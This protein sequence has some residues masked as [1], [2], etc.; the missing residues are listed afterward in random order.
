[1]YGSEAYP[2]LT[3]PPT[4][5]GPIIDGDTFYFSCDIT[6][7]GNDLD[8]AFEFVWLF[9]GVENDTT[10]P[11][12]I[13]SYST[14]SARLDGSKLKGLLNKNIGC[15]V[16]AFYK[17]F[18]QNSNKV[19]PWMESPRTYWA[20]IKTE[21]T[22]IYLPTDE[23]R[24]EVVIKPP[25]SIKRLQAHAMQVRL[26]QQTSGNVNILYDRGQIPPD[27]GR[28]QGLAGLLQPSDYSGPFTIYESI[29]RSSDTFGTGEGQKQKVYLE[30]RD[31]K[32]CQMVTDPHITGLEDKRQFHLLNV[33]DYTAYENIRRDFEVQIRT[34]PCNNDKATCICGVAVRE[35][36]DL[37]RVNGCNHGFYG[38]HVGSPE[39][40]VPRPLREGTTILQATDGSTITLYFPSGSEIRVT[41]SALY[42]GHLNLDLSVPGSDFPHGRGLCGTFDN[43]ANNELT[44]RNGFVDKMPANNVPVKFTESWKI[45]NRTSLFDIIPPSSGNSSV[46]LHCICGKNGD[47]VTC[48]YKTNIIK[49]QCRNCRVA[50]KCCFV[51]WQPTSGKRSANGG[52]YIDSD[53]VNSVYDP[54]RYADFQPATLSWPTPTGINESQAEN[55]CST[56]LRQSQ[57]WSHCQDKTQEIQ[58]LIE[59]CKIDIQMADK[60]TGLEPIV[61]AFMTIC[62]LELAK[63]PDNYVSTPN[64]ESIL[65]PAISDDVCNPVCFINGHCNKGNCVC[66]KGFIGDNCQI[67]DEPPTLS[68]IRGSSLCDFNEKPCRKI[69]IDATNIQNTETMAC[70]VQEIM[71]DGSV[72]ESFSKEEAVFLTLNKLGCSLPDAGIKTGSLIAGEKLSQYDV[73]GSLTTLSSNN[74]DKCIKGSKQDDATQATDD[75]CLSGNHKNLTD[76]RRSVSYQ[77]AYPESPLCDYDLIAA[78]TAL[79]STLTCGTTVPIWMRGTHPSTNDGIQTRQACANFQNGGASYIECCGQTMDIRVKNC[80]KFFVYYL[81]SV[82]A[83][84]MAYCA[85]KDAPCPAGTWSPTGF[86]PGCK[87]FYPQLTDPPRLRGP[88]IER[89]TFY[90]TCDLNFS[91]NDLDQAF[92][93][94]WLF[95]GL[96]D[97]KVTPEVVSE[98]GRSAR[99]DGAKLA[100]LLNKNTEPS[101]ITTMTNEDRKNVMVKSTVPVLCDSRFG[102]DEFCCLRISISEGG[103]DT[104]PYPIVWSC[105]YLICMSAWNTT[106]QEVSVTFP[107]IVPKTAMQ[108]GNKDLLVSFASLRVAEPS[109]YQ[110]IFQG[111]KIPSVHV[112]TETRNSKLC[113]ISEQHITGLEDKSVTDYEAEGITCVTYFA[114]DSVQIQT[115]PCYRERA[116]RA[117]TCVCGVAVREKDDL[118]RINGCNH[119][120]YGPSVGSPEITVPRRLREG[121]RITQARDGSQISLYFPSS[122]Q[123]TINTSSGHLSLNISVPGTDYMDGRG[124]CGTFDNNPTNEL[125]HRSGFVDK[126]PSDGVPESFTESWKND[127][128]SSLFQSLPQSLGDSYAPDYCWCSEDDF[129]VNCNYRRTDGD[130]IVVRTFHF[131]HDNCTDY[132]ILRGFSGTSWD[133]PLSGTDTYPQLT[134][135]PSLRGPVIERNTFYFTCDLTF[136]GNDTDQV[137]EF[138]WLFNGLEDPKVPPEIVPF[139]VR[140][141]RLEGAKLTGLLNK[142]VRIGCKVRGFFNRTAD[143]RGPWLQSTTTYWAGIRAEPSSITIRAEEDRKDLTIKSTLPILMGR[144]EM[145]VD[146]L[147]LSNTCKYKLCTS[148]WSSTRQE[149]TVTVSVV[150]R[151]TTIQDGTKTLLLSFPSLVVTEANPYL[152][153][154][155]GLKINSVQIRTWP[156]FRERTDRAVTCIC[157]VA[158]REKDDLIRINGCDHGFY[159]QSV[160]SPEITVPRPLREGTRILQATDGS[161][162]IIYFLS[163]S[164][165]K[166]TASSIFGGHLNLEIS[167]PGTDYLK[168]KGLCGTFDNNPNNELTH[169][170]GFVDIMPADSVPESFTESWKIESTVK[171]DT[172]DFVDTRKKHRVEM[173][174]RHLSIFFY[175]QSNKLSPCTV[176]EVGIPPPQT[177]ATEHS[178]GT[179]NRDFILL[180]GKQHGS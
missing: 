133:I 17:L 77:T 172:V 79:W 153:I 178:N 76:V 39:I 120:F 100:G 13:V 179:D 30:Q 171:T 177:K 7:N 138:V 27:S 110:Q 23:D 146:R 90:F 116:D 87:E 38:Q 19:G 22:H 92:E 121:T 170:D 102:A 25:S 131:P 104:A 157:G 1:M 60:Y 125:T 107:V 69:F 32:L 86:P 80:G 174:D 37:I 147:V 82:P 46:P 41:A 156:C 81:Y 135:P 134:D 98:P 84:P 114:L 117:V 148:S 52:L 159:G 73:S 44:H 106:L 62:Q 162:I 151:M 57:L 74:C 142:N 72:S 66:N 88:V 49:L 139:T 140:S 51:G 54:S 137:F 122:S 166:V 43:N 45:D 24:K 111:L 96:E 119:F 155:Q 53:E 63:D 169:R 47:N 94:V 2:Q 161:M 165:I 143:I 175:D 34:W 21:P 70:K 83:C 123:I 10:I 163:S 64:G 127:D 14:R 26:G 50:Q 20:G 85:G 132:T 9:D 36:D 11:P 136:S 101:S 3:H 67:K 126:M 150:A 93:F 65:M 105:R 8:Q 115:W 6:F 15:K 55:Y 12:E 5:L 31:S 176:Y 124:L 144:L 118:I 158:V 68:G 35:K 18:K 58:G 167:V 71:N 152:Q 129:T 164:E 160:G 99:L 29:Q 168:G 108:D 180:S 42:G 130:C 154:Y 89:N 59:N 61:D 56:A 91:G 141:A 103:P 4:L 78:G 173:I 40:T 128:R 48:T 145:F 113:S 149:A 75:P 97:P 95:N 112:R 16:R 33:G 109:P 28:Q